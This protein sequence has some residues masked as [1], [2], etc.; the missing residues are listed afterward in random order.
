M[1]T[2]E[3]NMVFH[4]IYDQDDQNVNLPQDI[5]Q[6]LKKLRELKRQGYT[7]IKD[8]WM[9][10]YTGNILTPI[11]DYITETKSYL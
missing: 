10:L 6:R 5:K 1:H 9:E 2:K 4:V 11:N 7:H 3:L 8:K